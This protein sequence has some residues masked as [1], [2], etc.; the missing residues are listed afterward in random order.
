MNDTNNIHNDP[1]KSEEFS[2]LLNA[3]LR[4]IATDVKKLIAKLLTEVKNH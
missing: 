4:K 2:L 1:L 3:V